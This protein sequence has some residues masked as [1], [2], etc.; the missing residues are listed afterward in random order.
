MES[1][2]SFRQL[3]NADLVAVVSRYAQGERTATAQLIASLAEFDRRRLYLDEGFTSLFDYCR[4]VLHLSEHSSY[5]RIEAAR[6]ARRFPCVVDMLREG[7]LSLTNLCLLRRHLTETN[8][9]ALL[10]EARHKRKPEV[11]RIVARLQPRP[12]VASAVRRLP[13][14]RS[15]EVACETSSSTLAEPAAGSPQ[16]ITFLSPSVPKPAIIAPLT[17]ERYKIQVTVDR[18]THDM[19][20]QAQDLMRHAIPNGDPALIIARALRLLVDD[21]LKKKAAV[22]ARPGKAREIAD[23]SRVIPA[24]VRREVWSR[25]GGRCAFEGSRGRCREYGTLEYHH[26]V[27]YAM[28]GQATADNIELRCRAHNAHEA[29]LAGLALGPASGEGAEV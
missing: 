29:R 12:D 6:A 5:A 15:A 9:V 2:S 28:G 3:S 1:I 23:G 22:T 10:Q 11:E 8:H 18:E 27:P 20:R 25:D 24:A 4:D 17:P 21:Q 7:S 13:A 16:P 14:P 26:V 19:L